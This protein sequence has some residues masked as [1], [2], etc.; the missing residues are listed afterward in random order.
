MA[1]QREIEDDGTGNAGTVMVGGMDDLL[2]SNTEIEI[3]VQE[4]DEEKKAKRPVVADVEE[5][6]NERESRL[7]EVEEDARLA[8]DDGSEGAEERLSRRKRRNRARRDAL[9]TKDAMIEALMQRVDQLSNIVN[10]VTKGQASLTLNTIDSQ[11]GA[12][13]QALQMAD[14]ELARAVANSDGEKFREIQKLRDEAS[15]RVF[16]LS[17]AKQRMVIESQQGGPVV[18]QTPQQRGQQQQQQQFSPKA[19]EYTETFLNRFSYFDPNGTDEDSML[20]RA[21]D[22]SVAAEGYRPDTPMY[23]RTLEQRLAARGFYPEKEGNDSD[24]D[25]PSPPAQRQAARAGVPPTSTGRSTRRGGGTTF[26]LD[27]MMTEYLR[28]EGL[29]E[30]NLPPEDKAR[31]DRLV[32][33]WR[34]NA[35][36]AKRGEFNRS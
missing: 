10:G 33:Q 24:D 32:A 7:K 26:Q 29:L 25:T 6:D 22:D 14:E 18:P 35:Q 30:P 3:E 4:T 36:R 2:G 11:L 21:I 17:T 19:T 15:T 16:Q 23:W 27:P 34:N 8:Y 28:G 20:I 1:R 13:Q 5:N 9:G 31:R 12:A